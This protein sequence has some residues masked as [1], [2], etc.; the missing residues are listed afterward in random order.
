MFPLHHSL[1]SL[2]L[3]LDVTEVVVVAEI[4]E[5]DDVDLLEVNVA[6]IEADRV[7]LRKDPATQA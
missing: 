6:R 3:F 2:S 5:D 4:S 1:S 7:P